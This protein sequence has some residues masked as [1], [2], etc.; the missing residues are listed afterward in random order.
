VAHECCRRVLLAHLSLVV[1]DRI[2]RADGVVVIEAHPR[3]RGSRC[4]RC[5]RVSARVH[6]RYR[7]RVADLGFGAAAG[8]VVDDAPVLL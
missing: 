4:G 2:D 1:I 8:G 5:G 7:R 6:S 3:A